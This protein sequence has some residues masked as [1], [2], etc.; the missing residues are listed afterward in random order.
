MDYQDYA[1]VIMAAGIGTRFKGGVKQLQQVGPCDE[2]LMEYA[3]YDALQSG[4]RRIVFI[5]RKDIEEMF[6]EMVGKKVRAYCKK[7]GATVEYA[8]QEIDRLPDGF[9]PGNRT[10]PWGTG[11]A[12][13]CCW[14]MLKTPFV[15]INA[16]DYYGRDAF[17]QMAEFLKN[18]PTSGTGFYALAGYRLANTLSEFGGVTRGVCKTEENGK[19]ISIRETRQIRKHGA[20]GVATADG[21]DVVLPGHTPVSMNM[22][23]FTPDVLDLFET[24]FVRFLS[25]RKGDNT[26][27]EFLI[28]AEIGKLLT[29]KKISVQVIATDGKWFGLTFREDTPIVQDALRKMTEEKLYPSPLLEV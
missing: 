6:E 15:V 8:Y 21:Q 27:G 16:D 26:E 1:L 29:G 11:H 12:L 20:D 28:P 25:D 24:E 5:I 14:H 17:T 13:L 10:R 3:V 7:R 19:L 9:A 23:A 18:L 2:C 22:W 4:F